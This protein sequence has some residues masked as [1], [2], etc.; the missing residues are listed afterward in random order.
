MDFKQSLYS[1]TKTRQ[2]NLKISNK[3]NSLRNR[4]PYLTS[5]EQYHALE[6][7]M[8]LANEAIRT[9]DPVLLANIFRVTRE[10]SFHEA[11][12]AGLK[13]QPVSIYFILSDLVDQPHIN[14]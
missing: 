4:A 14:K 11:V 5:S 10:G 7:Y 12:A 1:S 2:P 13:A 9:E 3:G 8:R 6:E